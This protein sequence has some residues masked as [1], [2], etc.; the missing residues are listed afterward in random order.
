MNFYNI[1]LSLRQQFVMLMVVL[2]T[3]KGMAGVPRAS[4]VVI[5]ASL[6][7]LWGAY[8][9][10]SGYEAAERGMRLTISSAASPT[11]MRTGSANRHLFLLSVR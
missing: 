1:H 4:I 11:K 10:G 2:L 7:L 3:S 9:H 6:P 5:S 8:P